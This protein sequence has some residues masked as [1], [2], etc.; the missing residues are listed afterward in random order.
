MIW[1]IYIF[2]DALVNWFWIEHKRQVPNYPVMTITRGW[3][4]ILTG[5]YYDINDSTIF[6]WITFCVFSFWVFFDA[7]L[8]TLRGDNIFYIGTNSK[9]DKFGRKNPELYFVLKVI[10]LLITILSIQKLWMN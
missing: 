3:F 6:W 10:A 9:I 4:L 7:I 8:N 5:I 1:G 2:L